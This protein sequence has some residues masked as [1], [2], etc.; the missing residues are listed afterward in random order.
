MMLTIKLH[1]LS[2]ILLMGLNTHI[3]LALP[4]KPTLSSGFDWSLPSYAEPSQNAGLIDEDDGNIGSNNYRYYLHIMRWDK[5]N[6]HRGKYDFSRLTELLADNPTKKFL[7][8]LEVNSACEAPLWALKKL[9][10]TKDKSLIFWDER[11]R[12]TLKPFIKVFAN[13]FASHPQIIGVQ[14]G[15]GDGKY[16]GS[17]QSFDNKDGWGEFWMTEEE[18]IKAEDNFALTP[19]KF[20][21]ATFNIIDDYVLAFGDNKHK[22]AFTNFEPF[23]STGERAEKYNRL[24]PDIAQ[25][26]LAQGI[27]N[28]DGAIE[29]WMRYTQRSY[30]MK[31][32]PAKNNSCHL[33]MDETFADTIQGRYWGTENEFYG[34]DDYIIEA[35]GPYYNQP[36][37][38]LLSSLRALQ[39]RR[40]Y[41]TT[42]ASAMQTLDTGKYH[43]PF[44][45]QA[46]LA[47]LS[48]TLG[49]QR[50][51][52]PDAFILFGERYIRNDRTS[53]YKNLAS[54]TQDQYIV[55]R[56]FGRWINESSD[57]Q[58]AMRI[59]MSE[60]DNRWGQDFY[61]PDNIHHEYAARSGTHFEFTLNQALKSERCIQGC[62]VEIK[63]TFKDSKASTLSIYTLKNNKS[64]LPT[65]GDSKIK[66]AS[67]PLEISN[68]TK[69]S[70]FIL[71]SKKALPILMVRVNFFNPSPKPTSH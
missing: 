42:H 51:N 58:A 68:K 41:I 59:T 14:L 30:G 22:L 67:F 71:Q 35:N 36:Y 24:M 62:K 46:F 9:Q 54:C 7:I 49:K 50:Y 4:L 53:E 47:Y 17:C 27:G 19:K 28:R 34:K 8:R 45:T 1:R 25:Y 38:F 48:K 66:T 20:K 13:R 21:Q 56:S 57:S 6:P 10:T 32:I 3:A 31:F 65:T 18:L 23:Y 44:N 55:V 43:T 5:T 26:A 16:N 2:F 63:V 64:S 70:D 11:Y 52:T 12:K 61:L 60:T 29:E 15:L 40:N 39:M 69:S 37:R 33:A